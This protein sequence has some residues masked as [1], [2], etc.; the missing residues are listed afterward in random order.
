[1]KPVS[2]LI[3]ITIATGF[4]AASVFADE[5]RKDKPDYDYVTRGTMLHE[6]AGG[7]IAKILIDETNLSSDE[8]EI[9]ELTFPV[10]Y[11]GGGHLHDAIEIFYVLSGR[12]GH[13][14]NGKAA[15]LGPGE[16]GIVKPGD[17]VAHS[18]HGDTVAVVLTIWV[19]GGDAAPDF[20]GIPSKPIAKKE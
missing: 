20:S 4:L 10:G 11:T 9:A 2:I 14:V 17:T 5:N 13:S 15:I 16:L 7:F 8:I 1:M 19:P 18:V 6:S 3:A 12:F